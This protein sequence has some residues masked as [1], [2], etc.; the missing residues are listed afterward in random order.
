MKSELKELFAAWIAGVAAAIDLVGGPILRRRR[1]L[2]VE[3]EVD[4]FTAR[5]ISANPGP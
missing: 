4:R 5:I 1:I 2:L 3:E